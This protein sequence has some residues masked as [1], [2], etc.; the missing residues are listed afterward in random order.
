MS[1]EV[2]DLR[3]EIAKRV[4]VR[5]EPEVGPALDRRILGLDGRASDVV[6][7]DDAH[8]EGVAGLVATALFPLVP[9]GPEERTRH[10]GRPEGGVR[11]DERRRRMTRW[12]AQEDLRGAVRVEGDCGRGLGPTATG[13]EEDRDAD[14]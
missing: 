13:R 3:I 1:A 7:D 4:V 2:C 8:V 14:R 6:I 11:K 9:L 10:R 5:D 12:E